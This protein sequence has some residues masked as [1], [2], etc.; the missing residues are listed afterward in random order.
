MK[1]NTDFA[2]LDVKRGRK[3]LAK[4]VKGKTSEPARVPVL[5]RGFL[6]NVWSRDDGVSIEFQVDVT[7]AEVL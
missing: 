5:I 4:R 7:S 6:T 1:L 2:I 3:Q